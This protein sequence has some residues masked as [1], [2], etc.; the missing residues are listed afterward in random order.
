[1]CLKKL[2]QIKP[3]LNPSGV[4]TIDLMSSILLDKLEEIGDDA[5]LYLPDTNCKVYNKADVVKFLQL[6]EISSIPYLPEVMDCDDFAAKA[7]GKGL[8]LVW[9]NVHALN[10]FVDEAE[11]LWFVEPQ[12]DNIAPNLYNWQGWEI[13]FFLG[14]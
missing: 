11:T 5:E 10:Y 9:T 7:Y 12:T 2:L 6:D 13:R 14:R 1:M 3:K 4:I 8:S